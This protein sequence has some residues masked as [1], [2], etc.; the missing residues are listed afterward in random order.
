MISFFVAPVAGR[1][2]GR[3]PLRTL[4]GGGLMLVGVALLLMGG[5]TTG[6]S[7]THLLPG[8]IIAGAGVGMANPTLAT[9]AV[10][11]VPPARSGMA[12]GINNT[13]RQT[14]IATGIAGLGAIFQHQVQTKLVDALAGTPAAGRGPAIAH[15]VSS[16]EASQVIS[17]AP[18]ASR[19]AIAHA[20]QV[21]FIGGM[22]D[23]F[24]VAGITAL[25]GAV[26]AGV[27]VRQ[28]D[29]VAQPQAAAAAAA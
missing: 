16:G 24:V 29:F 10:G 18:P 2:A 3:I 9:T 27:L 22:N 6:S 23:L 19:G 17:T 4:L 15:A 26:L 14:G 21:A 11:V 8:F 28:S 13:F 7:W 5:L 25:V 20:A 1:L 12:S